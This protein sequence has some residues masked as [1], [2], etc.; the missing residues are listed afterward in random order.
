MPD[1]PRFDVRACCRALCY[2]FPAFH[3]AS[4]SQSFKDPGGFFQRDLLPKHFCNI[5]SRYAVDCIYIRLAVFVQYALHH[6]SAAPLL[7]PFQAQAQC[8]LCQRRMN[9]AAKAVSGFAVNAG[10]A[11]GFANVDKVPVRRL[12]QQVARFRTDACFTTAHH[13]RNGKRTN[14]VG[15]QFNLRVKLQLRSIQQGDLFAF[16]SRA[17]NNGRLAARSLPQQVVIEGMQGLTNL[18]HGVVRGIHQGIN[19]AHPCQRKTSPHPVGALVGLRFFHHP[20][21]KARVQ[22]GVAHFQANFLRDCST[23]FQGN[24]LR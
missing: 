24:P 15:H 17:G 20:Q 12:N 7:H 22:L 16:V 18:E 6:L 2:Q 11:Q 23:L 5:F 10:F 1:N 9:V 4:K 13:A 8:G 21:H 3:P 14:G 19:R